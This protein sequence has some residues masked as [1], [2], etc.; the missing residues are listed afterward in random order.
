[1]HQSDFIKKNAGTLKDISLLL[2]LA[3][4]IFLIYSSNLKGTF[5]F[6]DSRLENNPPLHITQ[7]SLT[8]LLKAGFKSSPSTR[9]ISYITFALNFYFHGFQTTG[10]HLVNICIHIMAAIFLFLLI[11]TTLSLP[12][13][14]IK[15]GKYTWLPFAVA[16][17]WAVHPLQTQSVT[18][19][20][21][22]MNSLSAMFYILAFYLYAR[23]RLSQTR[24]MKWL[25]FF[26]FFLAGILSLGSKETAATLPFFI[27]LYEW[28]FFQDLDSAW[29]KKQIIPAA[30]I[31]LFFGFLVFLYLG[32][33]P[34]AYI[35]SSYGSRNFTLPERI[36]TEFRVVVFYISLLLF[37]HPARLNLDHHFLYSSSLISPITTLLSMAFLLVLL[38]LAVGT[39]RRN[40]LFSFCIIWFLGNLVIESS[41]IGLE[42]IFEHRNYLPSMMAILLIISTVFQLL[43][44]SSWV[45]I[46]IICFIVIL[47]SSWTYDRNSVWNSKITLWSD[48][49]AKSPGKARPHNNLGY[50]LKQQGRLK[51]ALA[52]YQQTIRIDPEFFEAY[53]NIGNIYMMFGKFDKAIENYNMSLKIKAGNPLVH[54]NIGNAFVKLWQL[55]KALLHYGEALHLKPDYEEARHRFLSTQNM[56]DRKKARTRQ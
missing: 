34:L 52:H 40:R 54:M 26:G 16:L 3:G 8:N 22:R 50:A 10:Y 45:K 12:P 14:S 42:I 29:L 56:L 25:F 39:A 18:Y 31:I 51:E 17:V 24:G 4:L 48:C 19:I 53:N 9:P 27:F 49:A 23:G 55:E 5:I 7:L 37:P 32:T 46:A 35:L 36:L 38:G 13:L 21:Q 1:M 20:I 2:I 30:I 15:Y 43:H 44:K 11:K 41:V 6:D 33:D 47:L 28:Y